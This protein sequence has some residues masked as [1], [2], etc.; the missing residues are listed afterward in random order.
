M[1]VSR[2]RLVAP[3]AV[4]SLVMGGL[5]AAG[6]AAAPTALAA[7]QTLT[8]A[9]TADTYVLSSSTRSN[10]GT[11]TTLQ[12]LGPGSAGVAFLKFTL[13]AFPSGTTLTG[14]ALTVR[15]TTSGNAGSTATQTVRITSSSWTETGLT[16]RTIPALTGTVLGTLSSPSA[17]NTA[18][19]VPLSTSPLSTL[20]G[21]VLSVAITSSAADSLILSSRSAT[22]T[23]SRPALSLTFT[24]APDTSAP[25]APTGLTGTI[26][27]STAVLSW[28]A[29]TDNVGVT[30][31][32]VHRSTSATFTPS[33]STLLGSTSSRT[34]TNGPL[35][36][37]A[38]Y[39]RVVARDAAG[40]ASAPSAAWAADIADTA[41][42]TAPG[43]LTGT[44][45]GSTASLAWTAST[46]DV[47]VTGYDVYQS[48]DAGFVPSPSTL[49][50]SAGSTTWTSPPLPVGTWYFRVVAVDA[51]ENA[52]APSGTWSTTV[53]PPPDTAAPSQPTG[54]DASTSGSS[55]SL[56]WSP[57]ADNVAT[58]GYEVHRSTSAAFTPSPSTM[59]ATV[60]G[61]SYPDQGLAVGTYYYAVIAFDAAGNRSPASATAPATIV[62]AADVTPPSSPSSL[63][64]SPSGTSPSLTWAA[65]TDDTA[66]TG[67]QV[68][69]STDPAFTPSPATLVGTTV[70]PVYADPAV[71]AGSWTY[72]VVALDGAS[73]ASTASV[74]LTVS[75]GLATG[76]TIAIEPTADT[77]ANGGAP[78][79]NYG[80]SA[81]IAVGGSTGATAWLRFVLPSAPGSAPLA[82]VNLRIRNTTDSFAGSTSSYTASIGPDTWAET[83]LTWAN[84][85][86]ITGPVV[87]TSSATTDAGAQYR[88]AL[89]PSAFAARLGQSTT[90]TLGTTGADSL[91]FWSHEQSIAVYHPA[92]E[93]RFAA[94]VVADVTPPSPPSSLQ[95]AAA[96]STAHVTWTASTDASGI[97]YYEADT[98]TDPAFPTSSTTHVSH[99]NAAAFNDHNRAPGTYWYRAFAV[100]TWGNRSAASTPISVTITD[101]ATQS[102]LFVVGDLVCAPGAA[103][104]TTS[105]RHADV[106]A[107][108][109]TTDPDWF[110]PDGDI[111][112]EASIYSDY[113]APGGYDATFGQFLPRTLPVVGNHEYVDATGP[114]AGYFTYFDPQG[115]GRFGTNPA[116]YYTR[117]LGSWR[118][119][120]LNSECTSDAANG[121][122]IL[123]GGCAVGSPEYTWL[124]NVLSTSTETCQ[125]VAFH[126]ARWSSGAPGSTASYA[127][128]GAMWDLMVQYGVD[129]AVSGHKHETEVFSPIGASGT[130][131][132][133]ASPTG[134]KQFV[135]G[136]GGY[137]LGPFD[138]T[139]TPVGQLVA[140]RDDTSYGGLLLT[141]KN[142]SY[143]WAFQSASGGAYVNQGTTG[144][145]GGTDVSCH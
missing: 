65:S 36:V 130:G 63:A 141:L 72:R 143:D 46:D 51:A 104:T 35:A 114:A 17:V 28:A 95:G 3:V 68:Y 138:A 31:Y 20:S 2:R 112:Y 27:G 48:G 58:T 54:L 19:A 79:A 70:T 99:L 100:D 92:L 115:S 96:P 14:A 60:A 69:R 88:I 24:T 39:F 91:W 23:T 142:G 47:G 73:N 135:S 21:K 118:L 119:I 44:L 8:V 144:P 82:G 127:G 116:G 93:L 49:V 71:T 25:S 137:N 129:L 12:T 136:A 110:M 121:N 30:S 132:P 107:R 134:I 78:S 87:G 11:S 75:I 122:H 102:T 1:K 4:A 42:P 76:T 52:S 123:T 105:C 131:A 124:Q 89:T 90:V 15:T 56:S 7:T 86:A 66:V 10:Y 6:I 18:Y 5:A 32:D 26:N 85:P 126:R 103:V 140:A 38:W 16:Y 62:P 59:I 61:T 133:V 33:A 53:L 9:P 97:A 22:T 84:Q 111:Q 74:P 57:A 80:T 117:T 101:T 81:S 13:P 67:Y 106:A 120:V 83:T 29:S 40:N 64:I 128:M 55:V 113:V 41:P 50:G 125:V 37:G 145:F 94:S 139:T 43:S 109:A 45:D 108:V 34:F 77:Y 98:S